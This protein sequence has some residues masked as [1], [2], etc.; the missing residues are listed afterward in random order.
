MKENK[1]HG[2][3]LQY[4]LNGI[5]EAFNRERNF[6]IHLVVAAIVIIASFILRLSATEWMFILLAIYIVLVAELMNSIAERII[7]HIKPE[8]HMNAKI[9]KDIGAAIVLIAVIFSVIIGLIVFLPKLTI[10]L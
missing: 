5:K 6:R 8:I 9:I 3:G 4:A 1:K 10:L 2:I 7:D